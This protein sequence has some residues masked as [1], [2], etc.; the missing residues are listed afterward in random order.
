MKQTSYVAVD[1]AHAFK[2]RGGCEGGG[3]SYLGSDEVAFTLSTNQD[4]HIFSEPRS[5]DTVREVS[6][7]ITSNYGKQLDSSDTALGPNVVLHAATHEVAGTFKACAG[8]GGWSDEG[9]SYTVNTHAT[10]GVAVAFDWQSGGDSRGLDPK[11]TAQ[12]QRSQVPAVVFGIEDGLAHCLRS[13][14]SKADKPD[15]TTYIATSAVRRLTPREC[16]RL[17]GFPDDYTAIPWRK[18]GSEDCP[19][20][21]R[22]KALGNSMAVPV[23]R[24]IGERI[25][26]V[27][28]ML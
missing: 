2:V 5:V 24:W 8:S 23:M 12:L 22:Y 3:K 17:Q 10:Q 21:P 13:G 25:A 20:G 7:T 4:Q 26:A 28:D 11:D 27:E 16:E 14:A 9:V 15:S 1:A 18:K 19:D 6:P